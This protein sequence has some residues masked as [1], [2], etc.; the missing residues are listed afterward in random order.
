MLQGPVSF[1]DT[2]FKGS[3]WKYDCHAVLV[4]PLQM[5]PDFG[6]GDVKV[7]VLFPDWD[8]KTVVDY[9]TLCYT[10]R[11]CLFFFVLNDHF[12]RKGK[13]H[14]KRAHTIVLF[15]LS[16]FQEAFV[17]IREIGS[18]CLHS[19]FVGRICVE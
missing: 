9:L 11:Y 8:Q 13:H 1:A 2:R 18:P 14:H 19:G 5:I 4:M 3:T 6:S 17:G 7:T 10:G 12:I 16:A 15:D